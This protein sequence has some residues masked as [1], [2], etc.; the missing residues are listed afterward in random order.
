MENKKEVF[1]NGVLIYYPDDIFDNKVNE[2]FMANLMISKFRPEKVRYGNPNLHEPDFYMDDMCFEFTLASNRKNTNNFVQ[3]IKNGEYESKDVEGDTIEYIKERAL[4]KSRKRYS[5]D[6]VNL[7]IMSVLPMG[8]LD[9]ELS[10]KSGRIDISRWEELIEYLK[11]TYLDNRVF[12]NIFLI[13]PRLDASWDIIDIKCRSSKVVYL[14]EDQ[15]KENKIPYVKFLKK[16]EADE[17]E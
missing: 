2:A 14:T 6:D 10:T 1:D 13:M 4:E 16:E 8:I 5:E 9:I 15:I 12:S 7:C 11:K 17:T 3:M